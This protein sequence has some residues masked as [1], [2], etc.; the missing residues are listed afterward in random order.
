MCQE[1]GPLEVQRSVSKYTWLL[2]FDEFLLKNYGR[3]TQLPLFRFTR[4]NFLVKSQIKVSKS[5]WLLWFDVFS[6]SNYVESWFTRAN[7]LVKSQSVILDSAIWQVFLNICTNLLCIF[8]LGVSGGWS[9]W[10]SWSSCS[11]EC[12]QHRRRTCTNPEPIQG[13]HYCEG[14]DLQSRNCSHGFC[15]GR[16]ELLKFIS[17]YMSAK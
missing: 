4:A 6:W 9:G 2:L 7:F 12:F 16:L 1:A 15:Q 10:S 13:G 3:K 5:T 11:P 14:I 17:I 8:F